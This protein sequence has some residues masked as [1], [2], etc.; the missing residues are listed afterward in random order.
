MV[1][2]IN[3]LRFFFFF[4]YKRP[5]SSFVKK[6]KNPSKFVYL[7]NKHCRT[8]YKNYKKNLKNLESYQY[9]LPDGKVVRKEDGKKDILLDGTCVRKLLEHRF[10]V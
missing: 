2:F 4:F 1:L 3:L 7:Q 5:K 6:K 8:C 9:F 10:L